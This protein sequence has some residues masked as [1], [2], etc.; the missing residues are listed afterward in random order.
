VV[1]TVQHRPWQLKSVSSVF[2]QNS[3]F[4]P[5]RAA[6]GSKGACAAGLL[7]NPTYSS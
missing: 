4:A 7:T 6:P 1:M 2:G 5:N 3:W